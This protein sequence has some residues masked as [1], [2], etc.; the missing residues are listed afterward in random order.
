MCGSFYPASFL[1][2]L[3]PRPLYCSE[4]CCEPYTSTPPARL[5]VRGTGGLEI[6]IDSPSRPFDTAAESEWTEV[7]MRER[8]DL[9]VLPVCGLR[10]CGGSAPP[11]KAATKMPPSSRSHR[12]VT[13]ACSVVL[14]AHVQ[15]PPP[16]N[17][18]GVH[19]GSGT[20]TV[21]LVPLSGR[22][23]SGAA[24]R[25]LPNLSCSPCASSATMGTGG[26]E[27]WILPVVG[28][29]VL[30]AAGVPM[31]C[32]APTL[33]PDHTVPGNHVQPGHHCVPGA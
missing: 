25:S 8:Y 10:R 21:V 7:V 31:C 6:P 4:G 22:P 12:R 29:F 1:P 9:H 30:L 24:N 11:A 18:H 5:C 19:G 28:V 2:H 15:R 20:A 16:G 3:G 26:P 17:H 13:L 33:R 23:W 14:T 27:G 32:K